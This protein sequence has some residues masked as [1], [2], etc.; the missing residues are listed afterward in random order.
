[1]SPSPP[2]LPLLPLLPLPQPV[3]LLM[4][5]NGSDLMQFLTKLPNKRLGCGASGEEDI[6]T[7][8]F[9]RRIDWEKIESREVQPPYKPKI[10]RCFIHFFVMTTI[11]FI[12][13]ITTIIINSRIRSSMHLTLDEID[14]F[15]AISNG[16]IDWWPLKLVHRR[17][18]PQYNAT[19]RLQVV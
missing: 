6:R 5:D 18:I 8:A 13:I 12:S 3:D 19:F 2:L 11:R 4:N 9:F 7:N 14:R 10:V 16:S 17:S 15:D 1:M